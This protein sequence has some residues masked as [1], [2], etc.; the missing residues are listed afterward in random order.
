MS[1]QKDSEKLF[2]S[3]KPV[4]LFFKASIPGAIGMLASSTYYLTET[5]F[6][7]RMLGEDAFAGLNLAMPFILIAFALADLVGVGSSVP[8]SIKL[9]QGKGEEANK[10]FS[11]AVVL[12]FLFGLLS[13][14][15]FYIAAPF[16][17]RAMGADPVIAEQ[18]TEYMRV[19]AIF[20]PFASMSFAF[21]NYTRISGKINRSMGVNIFMSVMCF[22]FQL[23]FLVLMRLPI[24]FAALASSLGMLITTSIYM[25][26]FI[27]GKMLLHFRRPGFNMHMIKVIIANGIPSFLSNMS[28]R[29]VSIVMNAALLAVG[30]ATA[31]SIYGILMSIDGLVLPTM[32]GLCD[33]L[34]PAV[35]YNWGA[36]RKDR[37]RAIERCCYTA[38]ITLCMIAFL[39]L[40]LFPERTA[41]LFVSESEAIIR[42]A[43]MAIIIFAFNYL[44]RW[45]NFSTQSFSASI[46]RPLYATMISL[47]Q[48]FV[49]PLVFILT[50]YPL[51]QN[52]LLANITA[53]TFA[54]AV[55]AAII[56][57]RLMRIVSDK[58]REGA[59]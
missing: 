3:T 22:T 9:G 57:T 26:P 7:G 8:I 5:I 28:G 12:I 34:Q 6:V 23:I 59:N 46:G 39:V 50:L 15:F 31:V 25:Y 32:Y 48:A 19:Y 10:V 47:S 58:S 36:G 35:G 27:R 42:G 37:V 49:F 16:I 45:L 53:S 52:G 51:G 13:G 55:V 56:L 40:M 14:V 11:L 17:F 20:A 2:I 38:S 21:D 30:G 24:A 18:A 43:H 54:T 29:I 41:S 33:S 1:E 4:R 44:I